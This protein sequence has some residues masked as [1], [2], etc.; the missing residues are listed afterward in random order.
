MDEIKTNV[1]KNIAMHR[2]KLNLTQLQL[3]EKLNYSDKAVS[4]WERGEAVPDI[5]IM[6]ELAT[7]FN[8]TV[9][10]L[11]SSDLSASTEEPA[12]KQPFKLNKT[13]ITLLSAGLVWLIATIAFV[14]LGWANVQ[15]PTWL[16]FIYAIPVTAIVTLVFNVLWGKRIFTTILISVLIWT[17]ALAVMLTLPQTNAWLIFIVGIPLQVLTILW[18]FLKKKNK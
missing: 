18:F 4:K 8:V 9:D 17:V 12:E 7:M 15:G 13:V 10:E 1:A 5:Y 3:A 16:A 2:K 11:I 6:H 14:I